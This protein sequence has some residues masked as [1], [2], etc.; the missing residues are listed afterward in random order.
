[1]GG[2]LEKTRFYQVLGWRQHCRARATLRDRDRGPH[3]PLTPCAGETASSKLTSQ[4]L[5]AAIR[6]IKTRFRFAFVLDGTVKFITSKT[7]I[8]CLISSPEK[9]HLYHRTQMKKKQSFKNIPALTSKDWKRLALGMGFGFT[10][11]FCA[12]DLGR[13]TRCPEGPLCHLRTGMNESFR[14]SGQVGLV[15]CVPQRHLASCSTGT[16]LSPVFLHTLSP[17]RPHL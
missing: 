2:G 8:K 6:Q 13:V 12:C 11:C 4:S 5:P 7:F 1:M 9:T 14:W 3:A 10:Y 17:P 16:N 15:T